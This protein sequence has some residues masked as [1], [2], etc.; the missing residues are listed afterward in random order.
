MGKSVINDYFSELI[1]SKFINYR[2]PPRKLDDE[3]FF[4]LGEWAWVNIENM[5]SSF[6]MQISTTNNEKNKNPDCKNNRDFW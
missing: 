6:K 2:L 3:C 5:K 4:I 1:I